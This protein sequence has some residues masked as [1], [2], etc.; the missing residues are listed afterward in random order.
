MTKIMTDSEA[1]HATRDELL[2]QLHELVSD[3]DDGELGALVDELRI[4]RKAAETPR[5]RPVR[6]EW[7]GEAWMATGGDIGEGDPAIWVLQLKPDAAGV[8]GP[9]VNLYEY[10]DGRYMVEFWKRSDVESSGDKTLYAGHD[11]EIA[12]AWVSVAETVKYAAGHPSSEVARRISDGE[13]YVIWKL[14]EAK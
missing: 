14:M 6:P 8:P 3:L 5:A 13:G 12:K 1:Y 11:D 4:E 9:C 10:P 2:D 7:L